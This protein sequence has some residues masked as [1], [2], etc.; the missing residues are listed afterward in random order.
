MNSLERIYSQIDESLKKAS[1]QA[2]QWFSSVYQQFS[3]VGIDLT[4]VAMAVGYPFLPG[5]AFAYGVAEGVKLRVTP[6]PPPLQ[7][8]PPAIPIE[9][10]PPTPPY[11]VPPSPPVA[12]R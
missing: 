1:L 10:P 9:V 12:F 4:S 3:K 2:T 8:Y 5:V 7:E 6:V 11:A